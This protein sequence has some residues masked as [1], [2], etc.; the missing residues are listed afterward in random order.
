[1][2]RLRAEIE[3]V[4]ARDFLRFLL[5]WQRVA[6]EAAVEGV[7]SV[8]P[9]IAQLE[10]F[11]VPA[12][13]W[14]SEILPARIKDYQP[15]WLDARCLAGQAVWM[16][17]AQSNGR[18]GP[19]RTTPIALVPRR[20]VGLWRSLSSP[21]D[22]AQPSPRVQAVIEYLTANGASF[23]D[24]LLQSCGLLR[25][26]LEEA[27]AELVAFGLVTADSFAGLRALLVPSSERRPLGGGKRR[28]RMSSLG[29]EQAGRWSLVRPAPP[30]PTG[31]TDEAAIEH[32]ARTLLR[33]YGVVF[34]RLMEREAASLPPWRELLYVYR[35]LE[36]GGEIRGGRFVA[37]F[38]GEQFALPDAIGLL[39]EVRRR[40][41]AN[42]WTAVS[43][44]DPLNLAGILTPGPKLPALA[45]NRLLYRDGVPA[46]MLAGGEV[47]FFE[48]LDSG[49][50]WFARKALLRGTREAPI[51]VATGKDPGGADP[52]DLESADP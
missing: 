11:A 23:F 41:A 25:T 52:S 9:I 18:P 12:G 13:A 40:P 24:E 3:P 31:R 46:A 38:T 6:P 1:L 16:R 15:T 34:W 26:Q 8:E 30:T 2:K 7:A 22:A 44:V 42:E 29:V 4:A 17:L 5:R 36:A 45:G 20:H 43:G 28:R 35:R 37:G 51:A 10:G 39:R 27:L 14:E 47:R 33:R 48:E 19:V 50:E 49:T 21:S 32:V